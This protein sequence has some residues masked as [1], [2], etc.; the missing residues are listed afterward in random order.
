MCRIAPH[1]RA[2]EK[3]SETI[4]QRDDYRGVQIVPDTFPDNVKHQKQLACGKGEIYVHYGDGVANLRLTIPVA[5]AGTA[6]TNTI[7]KRAQ[8]CFPRHVENLI[9][10]TEI[11]RCY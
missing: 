2:S 10:R 7:T 6:H 3:V 9:P 1:P 8:L 11:V 4:R 5:K